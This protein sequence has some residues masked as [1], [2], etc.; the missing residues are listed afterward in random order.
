M[1]TGMDKFQSESLPF[2]ISFFIFMFIAGTDG[3]EAVF[4]YERGRE[5]YYK[6]EYY[7]PMIAYVAIIGLVQN[8]LLIEWILTL[9]P[10]RKVTKS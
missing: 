4:F 9:F 6:V 3:Y 2:M 1:R 5:N 8:I 7:I 10:I